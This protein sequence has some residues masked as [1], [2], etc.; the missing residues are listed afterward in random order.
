MSD[1]CKT[2]PSCGKLKRSAALSRDG[3]CD[4]C[5]GRSQP[6]LPGMTRSEERERE[7]KRLRDDALDRV[8]D[9]AGPIWFE[10]A[11]QTLR[12]VATNS[13]TFTTD[14]VREWGE[15]SGLREPREPRAWGPVMRRGIVSGVIVKTGEYVPTTR[16]DAHRRPIPVYRSAGQWKK[17]KDDG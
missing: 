16:P 11:F 5:G 2:C 1:Y 13:I 17:A 14:D 15:G 12:D 7:G 6:A 10:R 8:R 4:A 3:L 9:N